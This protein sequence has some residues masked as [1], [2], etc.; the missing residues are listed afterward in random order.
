MP[1]I[2]ANITRT[3]KAPAISPRARNRRVCPD[4]PDI[5]GPRPPTL[6]HNCRIVAGSGSVTRQLRNRSSVGNRALSGG[7]GPPEKPLTCTNACLVGGQSFLIGD[8]RDDGPST[9]LRTSRS[10]S[11]SPSGAP[12]GCR[13]ESD[14]GP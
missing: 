11:V 13:G 14:L 6:K 3:T 8:A 5:S 2:A 4:T 10:L 1:A 12:Q 9:I 7:T